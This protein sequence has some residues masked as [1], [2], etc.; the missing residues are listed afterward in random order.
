MNILSESLFRFIL[1]S[2][3]DS[4]T[5]STRA[6]RTGYGTE[7]GH[8]SK[9]QFGSCT[10][11]T[12]SQ[13]SFQRSLKTFNSLGLE[14]A[15][16]HDPEVASNLYDIIR[17]AL[18]E[19]YQLKSTGCSVFLTPSG[20]DVE[21][22]SSSILSN[23]SKSPTTNFVLAPAEIG[24][25]SV[26]SASGRRFSS[27]APD[28]SLGEVGSLEFPNLN[29]QSVRLIEFRDSDTSTLD[30][31]NWE[32]NLI[33]ELRKTPGKKILHYVN[34]SKTGIEIPKVSTIRKIQDIFHDEID[35]V[36]DAAQGRMEKQDIRGWI[37]DGMLVFITG[38]K[39]FSSP[40]FCCALFVPD[41][42]DISNTWSSDFH[43]YFD[44]CSFPEICRDTN[45]QIIQSKPR[46]GHLVR[47]LFGIENMKSYFSIPKEIRDEFI[48]FF[49]NEARTSIN[50]MG[51]AFELLDSDENTFPCHKSIVSFF[52]R[53]RTDLQRSTFNDLRKIYYY[54]LNNNDSFHI[55][56]PTKLL[57][58]NSDSGV[59]RLSIGSDMIENLVDLSKKSSKDEAKRKL[60]LNISQCLE[61][62]L[63]VTS[64]LQ[65][66][67]K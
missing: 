27:I 40:P 9:F 24:S 32:E 49:H 42:Y 3:A 58:E 28:G 33:L 67:S 23:N 57:H 38:S 37:D 36:V 63:A 4:R 13:E 6:N 16:L 56:Q 34:C 52:L 59:F 47:W 19:I 31:E 41:R 7:I 1:A 18:L 11:S 5:L 17:E 22:L 26:N 20:T 30:Y 15:N 10:A 53:N 66:Y 60:R 55:P 65:E 44:Q 62:L 8:S 43:T 21:M 2:D 29:N 35:I 51:G 14:Q 25:G 50:N 48:E 12:P 45:P 61:E 39:F 46:T 64:L 54:F